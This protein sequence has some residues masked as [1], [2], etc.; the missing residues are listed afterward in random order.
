MQVEGYEN[1]FALGDIAKVEE[2]APVL[3]RNSA[4]GKSGIGLAADNIRAF[5]K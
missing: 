5:L 4:T 3:S 1:V 2:V